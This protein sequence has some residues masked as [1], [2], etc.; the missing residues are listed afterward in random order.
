MSGDR[1]SRAYLGSAQDGPP[2][3][4]SGQGWRRAKRAPEPPYLYADPERDGIT[5][6]AQIWVIGVSHLGHQPRALIDVH[7]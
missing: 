2:Q 5:R 1:W 4:G 7:T 6:M 3:P